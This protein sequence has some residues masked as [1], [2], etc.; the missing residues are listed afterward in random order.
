VRIDRRTQLFVVLT[1]I[2]VSCLLVGD[3]IGGKLLETHAFGRAFV[4]SV[5]MIPFPITFLLTDL[6]NEFYGKRAARFITWVGFFC[7]AL[8]FLILQVSASL[9]WAPITRAPDWSGVNE[10]AFNNVF[11]GSQRI[12][13]ASMAAYLIAQ[14]TD[15]AIFNLLKRLTHNRLLWLRAT[16]STLISQAVDTVVIQSLAWF[17]ILPVG[18]IIALVLTSYVVKVVV[19][20]GLTPLIY[21]GHGLVQRLLGIEPVQL[22]A[23][24][25]EQSHSPS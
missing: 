10:S 5:G 15:I 7:A 4:I 17:G 12:L 6:L 9:S 1:S 22:D 3:I 21:A 23:H 11:A 2:F 20:V 18:E 13:Y 24:G 25:A 8:T 14:F 16:G 19:A